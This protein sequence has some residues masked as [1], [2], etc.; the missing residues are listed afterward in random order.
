[1]AMLRPLRRAR[2]V[3]VVRERRTAVLDVTRVA[4]ML[5]AT[6]AVAPLLTASRPLATRPQR[7][8]RRRRCEGVGEGRNYAPSFWLYRALYQPV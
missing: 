1:M 8:R 5:R 6:L 3:V 7:C 4:V 2:G